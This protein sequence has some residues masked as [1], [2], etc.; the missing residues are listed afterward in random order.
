[1]SS[2]TNNLNFLKSLNA[3][4]T[5]ILNPGIFDNIVDSAT[6]HDFRRFLREDILVKVDRAS[7]A[8]GLEIRSPFLDQ[9]I[10]DFAFTRV[11]PDLKVTST[12]R[13][14]LLKNSL[15][16][17]CQRHLIFIASKAFLFLSQT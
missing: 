14:I 7:M 16:D 2:R 8:N 3:D 4:N 5:K 12:N 1:M 9:K 10:I 11:S 13:K 6:Y 15:K 17:I